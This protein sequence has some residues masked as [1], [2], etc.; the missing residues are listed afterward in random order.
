M[1]RLDGVTKAFGSLRVL[2]GFSLEVRTGETVV[3]VGRSGAGKS[4]LLKLV[5]GLLRPDA[6]TVEVGG[7]SVSGASP[8]EVHAI[9]L[10]MGYVF[11]GAALFDSMTVAENVRL[12]LRRHGVPEA[13]VEEKVAHSLSVV[14]LEGWGDTM[15]ADLSGGMKK[16]AGVA[17]AVAPTPDYLLYDEPTSGLDPVTTSMIDELILRLEEE[18]RATS[19]VVTHDMESAYRVADRMALLHSGRVRWIGTPEAFREQDDGAIRAFV[20][21]RRELWPEE[22]PA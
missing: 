16:R 19:L 5:A 7:E 18:L 10:R 15:P 11:Q 22:D 14:G 8:R 2:R 3:V 21:G 1:I 9:R 13:E 4:V 20:E 6:G 17:R 12:A